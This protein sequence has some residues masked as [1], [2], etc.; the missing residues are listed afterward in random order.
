LQE[1]ATNSLRMR[2]LRDSLCL[3]PW[4]RPGAAN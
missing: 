1:I 3:L 4:K 2:S